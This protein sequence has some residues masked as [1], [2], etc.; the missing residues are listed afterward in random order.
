MSHS[1]EPYTFEIDADKV[2]NTLTQQERDLMLYYRG[3]LYTFGCPPSYREMAD[4][5]KVSRSKVSKLLTQIKNKGFDLREEWTT[6][7]RYDPDGKPSRV[8]ITIST[9]TAKSAKT[10]REILEEVLMKDSRRGAFIYSDLFENRKKFGF[11]FNSNQRMYELAR[12]LE[13]A[14]KAEIFNL[15]NANSKNEVKMQMYVQLKTNK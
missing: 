7:L 4:K 9:G 5:L 10:N 14:G 8:K 11:N 3:D 2:R 12:E 1:F 6:M 13:K 15:Y